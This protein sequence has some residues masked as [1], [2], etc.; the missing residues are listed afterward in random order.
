M[1]CSADVTFLKFEDLPLHDSLS[2]LTKFSPST[3]RKMGASTE[4]CVEM[5]CRHKLN[6]KIRWLFEMRRCNETLIHACQCHDANCQSSACHEMRK[7]VTHT[8]TC[9]K[10]NEGGC[11]ICK[12]LDK[13]CYFHAHVCLDAVCLVYACQINKQRV[14][15]KREQSAQN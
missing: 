15:D 12:T 14:K 13:L 1:C 8:G 3:P 5:N 11:D 6:E 9:Q 10:K 7:V 4:L 2:A